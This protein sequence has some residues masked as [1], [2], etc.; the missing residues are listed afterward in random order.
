MITA[1]HNVFG[2]RENSVPLLLD[3][4]PADTAFSL[5]KIRTAYSGNCLRVLRSTDLATLDIGFVGGVLDTATM[6]SFIGSAT[7]YVDRWYS[8]IG[9]NFAVSN[10]VVDMPRIVNAGVLETLNGKPAL[11]FNASATGPFMILNSVE[12]VNTD[13]SVFS[14]G[15][16]F[17]SGSMFAPLV[18]NGSTTLMQFT[19]NKYYLINSAGFNISATADTTAV[20]MLLEGHSTSLARTIY[21]NQSLIASTPTASSLGNNFI[22]IGGG[23][24]ASF[25][26]GHITEIILYKANQITNRV[27]IGNDII[28]RNS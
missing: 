27:A 2:R 21:K 25:T 4:Y 3:T 17:A 26:K 19:D 13:F 20:N 5:F 23:Y 6:L 12:V 8:Q 11:F 9:S 24:G 7:G 16:R 10:V 14:Y 15:K 22:R 1:H 28:T 18:T